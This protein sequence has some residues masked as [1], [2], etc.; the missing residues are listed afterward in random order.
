MT[1]P[2][3]PAAGPSDGIPSFQPDPELLKR[4]MAHPLDD[5]DASFPFSLR[6]ARENGWTREF[7]LAAI[8]EY[9]RF[10]YLICISSEELTP[11]DEVDQV[12]HQHLAYTRDYWQTFCETVTGKPIHHGPTSGGQSEDRR[13]DRNYR[14]TLNLYE[15]VF[16]QAPPAELWPPSIIRF[17]YSP[18]AGRVNTGLFSVGPGVN[19]NGPGLLQKLMRMQFL[20][21]STGLALL[22]MAYLKAVGT[23]TATWPFV[24]VA[25]ANL[26]FAIPNRPRFL[27]GRQL[28]YGDFSANHPERVIEIRQP[29]HEFDI[30]Y[31]VIKSADAASAPVELVNVSIESALPKNDRRGA[32]RIATRPPRRR[33]GGSGSGG[34]GAF[35]GGCGG[36]CGGGGCGGGGGGG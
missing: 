35:G 19:T 11:S 16:T 33:S 36:G 2:A 4:I 18:H 6:L 31:T 23:L 21:S 28:Q 25:I 34:G 7:A 14:R 15:A 27:R 10:I 8:E 30:K 24:M 29:H 17:S 5:P 1:D 22:F 9:R 32:T 3:D 20:A 13:Y 12:W 26:V